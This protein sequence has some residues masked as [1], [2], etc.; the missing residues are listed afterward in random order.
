[1]KEI[2][3]LDKINLNKETW[4]RKRIAIGVVL[5]VVLGGLFL[6]AAKSY[7][8][9][10][11]SSQGPGK[12]VSGISTKKDKPE[13]KKATIP[14]KTDVEEGLE[15]IKQDIQT[16]SL[17][18][19][20]SSSPQVQKVLQDIQSLQNLPQNQVKQACENICKNL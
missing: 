11:N 14:S 20:A 3:K 19:I 13:R 12:V 15:S 4:S 5:L 10:A 16:L 1:M 7:G 9:F 2:E 8:L 17:E 6:Y 18:E